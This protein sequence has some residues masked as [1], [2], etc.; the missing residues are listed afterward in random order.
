MPD[1]MYLA[2]VSESEREAYLRRRPHLG[3]VVRQ[4]SRECD[5]ATRK[6]KASV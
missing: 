3:A 6:L 2:G 1:G 5:A 4:V